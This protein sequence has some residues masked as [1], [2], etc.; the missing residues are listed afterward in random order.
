MHKYFID[1]FNYWQYKILGAVFATIFTDNFFQLMCL[2][3][4]LE[5]LDILTRMISQSKACWV[6]L[7]PQS[8]ASIWK[9][10]CFLWQARKWR[11]IKS[12]AMRSGS[13]K[14]LT[15]LLLILSATIVDSALKIGGADKAFLTTGVIVAFLAVTELLSIIENV[16]EFSENSVVKIIFDKIKEKKNAIH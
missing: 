9:Y 2:F 12:E 15:F 8:K 11:F 3:C 13:D 10:I 14:L 6:A 1:V 4:C 16:S 5:V 7:Y